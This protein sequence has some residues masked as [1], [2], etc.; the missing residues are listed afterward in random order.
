MDDGIAYTA[1]NAL[2][3][4]IQDS[5]HEGELLLAA[6]VPQSLPPPDGSS[7]IPLCTTFIYFNGFNLFLFLSQF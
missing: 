3:I 5:A 2:L 4:P 1:F 6:A 7:I